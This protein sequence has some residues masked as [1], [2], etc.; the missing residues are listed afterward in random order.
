MQV[1]SYSSCHLHAESRITPGP[2]GLRQDVY[3]ASEILS[4]ML[5]SFSRHLRIDC[6]TRAR[7]QPLRLKKDAHYMT[8]TATTASTMHTNNHV[9]SRDPY[10][11]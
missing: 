6:S 11:Q 7:Q 9:C 8:V 2:Q 5:Q 10:V 4:V 3:I 1:M